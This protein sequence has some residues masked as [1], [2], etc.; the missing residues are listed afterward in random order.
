MTEVLFWI[1]F[2]VL[3]GW[4]ATLATGTHGRQRVLG[5]IIIGV[6]GA[7][8]GG[9]LM[10]VLSERGVAGLSI[11]SLLTAGGG[12]IVLISLYRNTADRGK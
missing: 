11:P 3:A 1:L 7:I 6:L 8:V 10:R 12:A 5:N 9:L 4:I 2:G